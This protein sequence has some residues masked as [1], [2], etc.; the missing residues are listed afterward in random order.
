MPRLRL[1]L[2]HVYRKQHELPLRSYR[3]GASGQRHCSRGQ[4]CPPAACQKVGSA[5]MELLRNDIRP[6]DILTEAAFMN[7]LAR[8]IWRSDVRLTAYCTCWLSRTMRYQLNLDIINDPAQTP[9]PLPSQ[10]CRRTPCGKTCIMRAESSGHERA[11]FKVPYR[12]RAYYSD[13]QISRRNIA[14]AQFEYV[15]DQ[16]GRYPH[17]RLRQHILAETLPRMAVVKRSAVAEKCL[18]QN[19]LP[20]CLTANRMLS[21]PYMAT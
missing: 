9:N 21:K 6:L 20:E 13:R 4:F 10:P 12:Y 5:I 18:S 2:G 17:S 3:H 11:G 15:G 7:A 8:S 19:A 14:G 16:A 1:V